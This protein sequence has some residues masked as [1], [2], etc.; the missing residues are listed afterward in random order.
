MSSLEK[1][2]GSLEGWLER[3]SKRDSRRDL[4][5]D[6]ATEPTGERRDGERCRIRRG[7]GRGTSLSICDQ[8]G[9]KARRITFFSCVP[10]SSSE[11]SMELCLASYE[12]RSRR[13]V[14]PAGKLRSVNTRDVGALEGDIEISDRS[15][16]QLSPSRQRKARR[17]KITR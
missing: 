15:I 6:E 4:R 14:E 16:Q 11:R 5:K 2:A 17:K 9:R 13:V 1:S 7:G 8:W 12:K 3:S 10:L